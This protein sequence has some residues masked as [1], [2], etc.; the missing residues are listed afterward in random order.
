M[1]A[2]KS[3]LL[4]QL[5]LCECLHFSDVLDS[6]NGQML[7]I[8]TIEW[9]LAVVAAA[10]FITRLILFQASAA[11]VLAMKF[12]IAVDFFY[13]FVQ[14]IIFF[15]KK[16]YSNVSRSCCLTNNLV[17]RSVDQVEY[18]G[19][20]SGLSDL[21]PPNR[22]KKHAM[23]DSFPVYCGSGFNNHSHTQ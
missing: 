3:E 17:M 16:L 7:N 19:T 6:T 22:Q 4:A 15:L 20:N 9:I 8:H 18:T 10:L 11:P 14:L 23:I 12:A 13:I 1:L 21:T 2:R 5:H